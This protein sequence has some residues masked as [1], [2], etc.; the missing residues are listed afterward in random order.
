M[1]YRR[2]NWCFFSKADGITLAKVWQTFISY[3][4]VMF[5]FKLNGIIRLHSLFSNWL[6]FIQNIFYRFSYAGIHYVFRVV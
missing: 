6:L 4:F 2:T 5:D 3:F 1:R